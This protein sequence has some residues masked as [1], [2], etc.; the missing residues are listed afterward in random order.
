MKKLLI[1]LGTVFLVIILL[2]AFAVGVA[3][4]RGS[5]LDKESKAYVDRNLPLII[6]A[7]DEQ[8]LLSR[9]SP[10][11]TQNTK[12]EDLDKGFTG[13]DHKFGKMQSYEGSKG[14]SYI[15]YSVLSSQNGRVITAD[16]VARAT[17]AGGPATIQITLI[18][19]GDKW[20]IKRFE[21]N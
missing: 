5:A 11:F 10:E 8:E 16:Y 9:A 14:Q 13:L 7:W 2:V 12:R 3:A 15:N 6:S 21:I 17:F 19:H 18:K 1:I 4:V 20:Q